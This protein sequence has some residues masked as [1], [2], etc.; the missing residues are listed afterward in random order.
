MLPATLGNYALDLS[1]VTLLGTITTP[2]AG[3]P[4]PV[5]FSSD[6]TDLP[7][8]DFLIADTNKLVTFIFIGA[9]NEGEI[10]SKEHETFMAPT[11]TLVPEPATLALLGLGSVVLLRRRRK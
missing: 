8:G 4:Y 11:L 6:P 7:L 2:A 3:D 10:A 5:R 1:M 9:N